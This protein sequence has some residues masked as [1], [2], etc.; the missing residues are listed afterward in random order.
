MYL[1]LPRVRISGVSLYTYLI[2]SRKVE[3]AIFVCKG[4][5]IHNILLPSIVSEWSET[6]NWRGSPLPFYVNHSAVEAT[7]PALPPSITRQ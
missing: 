1:C 2:C 4:D 5:V 3:Q 6:T 7:H